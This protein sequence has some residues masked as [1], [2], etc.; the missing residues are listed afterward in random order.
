M[1]C[2]LPLLI[3]A[4][5]A[6]T[7]GVQAQTAAT[8]RAVTQPAVTQPAGARKGAIARPAAH[9]ASG[10]GHAQAHPS[11]GEAKRTAKTYGSA[12]ADKD[13]G[14]LALGATDITGNKELPKVMV[15]VPWKPAT[16]ADQMIKPTDSLLDEVLGPVD[17][18][19]FQRQIRYYR[20]I[21]AGQ[22]APVGDSH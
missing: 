20:Q 2:T 4:A 11:R 18:G 5:W 14:V 22:V 15:I 1:R 6:V 7:P 17:R 16:G 3:I 12:P 8:Q 21:N 19:M 10:R 9:D 13:G